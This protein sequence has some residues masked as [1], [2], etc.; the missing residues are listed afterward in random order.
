MSAACPLQHGSCIA[1]AGHVALSLG[2]GLITSVAIAWS[3]VNLGCGPPPTESRWRGPAG[4]DWLVRIWPGPTVDVGVVSLEAPATAAPLSGA[5]F[6]ESFFQSLPHAPW[7]A[8]MGRS[9]AQ[10][11]G[12]SFFELRAYGW[13]FKCM[14]AGYLAS[15]SGTKPTGLNWFEFQISAGSRRVSIPVQPIWSGLGANTAVFAVPWWAAL[16]LSSA[17]ASAAVRSMRRQRG[18]CPS[19]GYDLCGELSHGCPE[20]GWARRDAVSGP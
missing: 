17:A 15:P 10:V 3:G 9:A 1:R 2:L 11:S 14:A 16:G 19:C 5:E 13:P 4:H 6:R 18:R 12:G 8:M 20:C 7:R